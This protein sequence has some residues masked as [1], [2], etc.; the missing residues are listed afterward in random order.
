MSRIGQLFRK[1]LGERKVEP[2]EQDWHQLEAMLNG[3]DIK[4]LGFWKKNLN[5]ITLFLVSTTLIGGLTFVQDNSVLQATSVTPQNYHESSIGSNF[6]K[7]E[8]QISAT[9]KSEASKQNLP[10]ENIS[11]AVS[12]VFELTSN[13]P[14]KVISSD[15][16]ALLKG[17]K[18]KSTKTD[19][20]HQEIFSKENSSLKEPIA[21]NALASLETKREFLDFLFLKKALFPELFSSELSSGKDVF[22]YKKKRLSWSVGLAGELGITPKTVTGEN[23]ELVSRRNNEETMGLNA[24]VGF[25]V[26]LHFNHFTFSTGLASLSYGESTNYKPELYQWVFDDKIDWKINNSGHW[27]NTEKTVTLITDS[28]YWELKDTTVCYWN[29]YTNSLDSADVYT[30]EFVVHPK[31]TTTLTFNDSIYINTYDSTKIV[32]RD[33]SFQKVTD[34]SNKEKLKNKNTFRYVEIPLYIGY[35][36]QIKRWTI[37]INTGIGIGILTKQTVHYLNQDI[38]DVEEVEISQT[39]TIMYNYLLS[40]S[41]NYWLDSHWSIGVAPTYRKNLS[42][43]FKEDAPTQ[44][45]YSWIGFSAGV[46]YSF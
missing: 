28:S 27:Q 36:T 2:M 1:K 41:A 4:P 39:K 17:S 45:K 12:N 29:S 9:K 16:Q 7:A 34:I 31:D 21:E 42:S 11:S 40:A 5:N 20:F 25:K 35:E 46:K 14:R 43:L 13:E 3:A 26:G 22:A 44:Q 33:S 37:G 32:T 15:N 18:N 38:T 30:Y 6:D 19:Y 8:E 24:G 10:K 23:T